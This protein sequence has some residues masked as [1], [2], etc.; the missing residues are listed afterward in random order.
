MTADQATFGDPCLPGT[1]KQLRVSYTCGESGTVGLG[2]LR[3]PQ[4]WG[5]VGW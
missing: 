5:Q 4:P 3:V 2:R 1:R